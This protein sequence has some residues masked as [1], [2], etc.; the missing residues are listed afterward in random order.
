MF[1]KEL[2]GF[3]GFIGIR[4]FECFLYGGFDVIV[5]EIG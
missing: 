2:C 5:G 3:V 4:V 1:D